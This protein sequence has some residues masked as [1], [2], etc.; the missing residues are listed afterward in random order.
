M[1][2][3]RG[4]LSAAFLHERACM[5]PP[6]PQ[7]RARAAEEVQASLLAEEEAKAA[8]ERERRERKERERAE[9]N[10]KTK[11]VSVRLL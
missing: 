5:G 4:V 9:K 6:C 10:A 7:A 2:A 8:R 11:W 1:L 3:W